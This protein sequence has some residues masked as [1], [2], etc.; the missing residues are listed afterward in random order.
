MPGCGLV[1]GTTLIKIYPHLSQ[2]YTFLTH[3]T[4]IRR[5]V[6]LSL[7]ALQACTITLILLSKMNVFFPYLPELW[8][9]VSALLTVGQHL[10]LALTRHLAS[11]DC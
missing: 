10:L 9:T 4:H 5:S 1:P 6:P 8:Y 2:L 7:S 11:E 3:L